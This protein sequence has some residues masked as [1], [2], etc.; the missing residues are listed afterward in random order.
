M[1]DGSPTPTERLGILATGEVGIG[2]ATPT[3][4]LHVV[5]I[6]ARTGRCGSRARRWWG[7]R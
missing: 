5:V 2:T 4:L 7:A 6:C 1:A 3:S